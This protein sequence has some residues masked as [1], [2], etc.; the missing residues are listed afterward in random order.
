V[1]VSPAGQIDTVIE[2]PVKNITNCTFGGKDM[3]VL[4][5]TTA[6]SGARLSGSLFSLETSVKGLP[7]S[8]FAI[9]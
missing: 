3:N 4:Y 9:S 2:M 8:R 6:A 7:D 5:V 1:R